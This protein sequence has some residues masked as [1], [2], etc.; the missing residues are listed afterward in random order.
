MRRSE[1]TWEVGLILSQRVAKEIRIQ[2]PNF[3]QAPTLKT[4]IK[5]NWSLK[6]IDTLFLYSIGQKDLVSFPPLK[7]GVPPVIIFDPMF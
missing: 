1:Q 4:A 7:S 3:I 5:I 2:M 6:L